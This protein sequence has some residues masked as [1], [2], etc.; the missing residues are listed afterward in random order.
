MLR[1]EKKLLY[2]FAGQVQF[3]RV[4]WHTRS[5]SRDWVPVNLFLV[6]RSLFPTDRDRARAKRKRPKFVTTGWFFSIKFLCRYPNYALKLCQSAAHLR[7]LYDSVKWSTTTPT[8]ITLTNHVQSASFVY[9]I[10]Q[11]CFTQKAFQTGYTS[12]R[13]TATLYFRWNQNIVSVS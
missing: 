8:K 4:R 11:D 12:Y 2:I 7:S 10:T 6:R 9:I 13:N 3:A 1:N 5:C